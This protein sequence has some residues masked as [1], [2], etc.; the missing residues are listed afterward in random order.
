MKCLEGRGRKALLIAHQ[1]VVHLHWAAR[2]PP[3][4]DRHDARDAAHLVGTSPP[5]P[6]PPPTGDPEERDDPNPCPR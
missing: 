4:A 5:R 1:L 2:S 6:S 3:P